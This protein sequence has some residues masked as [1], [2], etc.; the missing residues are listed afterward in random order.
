MN[1]PDHS[2][3]R[4]SRKFARRS[5]ALTAAVLIAVGALLF[6]LGQEMRFASAEPVQPAET[7]PTSL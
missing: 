4:A 7:L 1:W 2:P 5:L 6:A 3:V